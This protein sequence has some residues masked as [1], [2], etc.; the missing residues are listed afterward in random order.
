MSELHAEAMAWL[1]YG[2]RLPIV[3]T[4]A[5]R[6]NADVLGM[7]RSTC[8]EVE[9][10]HSLSDLRAE[11]RNKTQKHW[12][13]ANAEANNG[14][15]VPNYFYVVVPEGLGEKSE[16]IIAEKAPAAGLLVHTPG[17]MAG[18]NLTLLRKAK[19]LKATPPSSAFMRDAILRMGSQLCGLNILH[20]QLEEKVLVAITAAARA[21]LDAA[22]ALHTAPDVAPF[23]IDGVNL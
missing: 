18:R 15:D 7:N 2:K 1:R 11:F 14:R 12:V 21:S 10:K 17:K 5:G 23:D 16:S 13:Y 6:W 20:A 8:I 19:K 3:C 22:S 4:E 9:V